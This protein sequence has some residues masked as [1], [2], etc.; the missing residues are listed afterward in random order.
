MSANY[1][2]MLDKKNILPLDK[3]G[4]AFPAAEKSNA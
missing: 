2:S 1:L 3:S 4:I